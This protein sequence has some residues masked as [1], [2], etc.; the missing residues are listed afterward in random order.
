MANGQEQQQQQAF[1]PTEIL[2]LDVRK[3]QSGSIFY[4]QA[5]QTPY[6][7]EKNLESIIKHIIDI[8]DH[9]EQTRRPIFYQENNPDELK[10][11]SIRCNACNTEIII[12]IPKGFA[13]FDP[14]QKPITKYDENIIE[15]P[16]LYYANDQR[17]LVKVDNFDP[18][19]VGPNC[20]L[21]VF[22]YKGKVAAA[23][24]GIYPYRHTFYINTDSAPF[25]PGSGDIG[26]PGGNTGG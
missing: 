20:Q 2:Y 25:F 22:S 21:A 16:R 19:N 9:P 17:H 13:S 10:P 24:R 8:G 4:H 7:S 5:L 14:K 1:I 23:D 18:N 15:N 6:V 3:T 12:Y 26:H 11:T